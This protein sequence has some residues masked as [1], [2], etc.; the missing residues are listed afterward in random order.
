MVDNVDKNIEKLKLLLKNIDTMKK[1]IFVMEKE[2][3]EILEKI[4]NKKK[5][6][7][8]KL[9]YFNNKDEIITKNDVIC[10]DDS[11]YYVSS[12]TE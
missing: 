7:F 10:E 4:Y 3:S 2:K 1:E 6:V 12:D 9:K 5:D 8:V 11:E